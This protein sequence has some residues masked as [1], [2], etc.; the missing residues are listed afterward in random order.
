MTIYSSCYPFIFFSHIF[1]NFE[2]HILSGCGSVNCRRVAEH[3]LEMGNRVSA[4]RNVS[5]S[6]AFDKRSKI[7]DWLSFVYGESLQHGLQ[8]ERRGEGVGW[9]VGSGLWWG[10]GLGLSVMLKEFG[11]F[12]LLII[13]FIYGYLR[14]NIKF[15]NLIIFHFWLVGLEGCILRRALSSC[16]CCEQLKTMESISCFDSPC[17]HIFMVSSNP[18]LL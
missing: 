16:W 12:L 14:E 10:D 4:L 5:S 9:G 6:R 1:W 2:L 13:F 3:K 11:C 8:F 18:F 15:Y 7:W 17:S